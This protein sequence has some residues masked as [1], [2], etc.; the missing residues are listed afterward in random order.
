VEL[1]VV[2]KT[3]RSTPTIEVQRALF[4]LVSQHTL[5]VACS[6]QVRR[7][8]FWAVLM[9][10]VA[11]PVSGLKITPLARFIAQSGHAPTVREVQTHSAT[12]HYAAQTADTTKAAEVHELSEEVVKPTMRGQTL[13]D[14]ASCWVQEGCDIGALG[15]DD[16]TAAGLVATLFR[17]AMDGDI[18]FGSLRSM[19]TRA[20]ISA[21]M[22][23]LTLAAV[24]SA[25][26][27]DAG[28]V[29]SDCISQAAHHIAK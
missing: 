16:G 3:R 5:T 12:L 14:L 18:S 23:K 19:A 22:H 2:W 24:S 9:M 27:T 7:L 8:F 13:D 17:F 15:H 20:C 25:A 21:A 29:F 26:S 11:V 28:Q 4:A 10:L 6:P 1:N